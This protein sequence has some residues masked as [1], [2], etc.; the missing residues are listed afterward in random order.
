MLCRLTKQGCF[1]FTSE[2]LSLNYFSALSASITW[3]WV[4]DRKRHS[5]PSE[6]S[7]LEKQ[8]CSQTCCYDSAHMEKNV[9]YCC[10]QGKL[11][12]MEA[13]RQT[14][15]L[16]RI[17]C[18]WKQPLYPLLTI[19][20]YCCHKDIIPQTLNCCSDKNSFERSW[21][22]QARWRLYLWSCCIEINK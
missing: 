18:L 11:A 21:S 10:H 20:L 9:N 12:P 4:T 8:V 3:L 2:M 22:S 15:T 17:D 19:P 14:S 6:S 5:C 1:F 13:T 7:T 16:L